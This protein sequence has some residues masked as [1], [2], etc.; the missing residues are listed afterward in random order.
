[1]R[2]SRSGRIA[3]LG[4]LQLEIVDAVCSL[5][6]ATVYDVLEQFPE[7]ERPHY[8]TVLTVLRRLE[9]KGLVTH[10]TEGRSYVYQPTL[11]PGELRRQLL[12][13]VINR[14]FGGSP[15]ALIS[16]LLGDRT[17]SDETLRELST[18]IAEAEG[19]QDDD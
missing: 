17:I 8:S 6:E 10:Q 15:K 13:D 11:E 14:V 16:A 1:M 3:E 19:E 18:L 9:K 12:R 4:E 2:E 7:Q 5:G